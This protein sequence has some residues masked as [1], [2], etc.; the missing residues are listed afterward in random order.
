MLQK[1][2]FFFDYFIEMQR[3]RA[4]I[5]LTMLSPGKDSS[6]SFDDDSNHSIGKI[7]ESPLPTEAIENDLDELLRDIQINPID[8]VIL[9]TL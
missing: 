1:Y 6:E 8:E 9:F 3:R 2:I 4:D 7:C 5:F